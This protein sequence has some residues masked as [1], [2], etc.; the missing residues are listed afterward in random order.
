M[1]EQI[2][3]F[4]D[5]GIRKGQSV[6]LYSQRGVGRSIGAAACYMMAKYG[7]CCDKVIEFFESKSVPMDLN[8]GLRQQLYELDWR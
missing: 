7:W 6:L 4:V 1:V 3:S 2:I 5:E 8:H